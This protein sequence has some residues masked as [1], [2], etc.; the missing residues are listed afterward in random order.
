[1]P[2]FGNNGA[3]LGSV[4]RRRLM[5]DTYDV[6]ICGAGSGGGFLAGEIAANASVLILEAGAHIGGA[7]NPG[8]GS[9]ERRKFATQIN[10]GTFI[11][12]GMYTF[13]QGAVSYQYPLFS[14]AS[15]PTARGITRE[16]RVVGGGSFINVGAWI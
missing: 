6:I 15:N 9:P 8:V 7:P 16:A 3:S 10:L 11:P 1:G 5:A 14:D 4:K 13:G 12:D 2:E